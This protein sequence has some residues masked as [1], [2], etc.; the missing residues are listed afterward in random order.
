M[1]G[2]KWIEM[3]VPAGLQ[4]EC[5]EWIEGYYR[6]TLATYHEHFAHVVMYKVADESELHEAWRKIVNSTAVYIQ[7]ELA[8]LLE[9]SNLYVWFWVE[10][11]ISLELKRKIENDTYSSKKFVCQI[12]NKDDK[13]SLL[14]AIEQRIFDLNFSTEKIQKKMLEKV[15]LRNF[16]V[17]KGEKVFSFMRDDSKLARLVVLFAPN[18]IGKTTFFDAVEWNLTS[19]IERFSEIKNRSISGRVLCNT[20]VDL[21]EQSFVQVYMDD[22]AWIKR[23]VNRLDEHNKLDNGNGIAIV[24]QQN[25]LEEYVGT[26]IWKK[27]ILQHHKIDGFMSAHNPNEWYKEWGDL[28]D[29]DYSKRGEF[30]QS[31]NTYR[32][33][34]EEY[35]KIE[36]ERKRAANE[37]NQIKKVRPFVVKLS[38]L[39]NQYQS[40]TGDTGFRNLD[41][42][43]M[44]RA[45]YIAWTDTVEKKMQKTAEE[46][47]VIDNIL[48]YFNT[49]FNE[50][51][52]EYEK[53]EKEVQEKQG[54][55]LKIDKRLKK[56]SEKDYILREI[57]YISE[58]KEKNQKLLSEYFYFVKK[59]ADWYQK[60]ETYFQMKNNDSS[61][62]IIENISQQIRSE[63]AEIDRIN[64][65]IQKKKKELKEQRVLKQLNEHTQEIMGLQEDNQTLKNSIS[66][67]ESRIELITKKIAE[68]EKKRIIFN[69]RFLNDLQDAK[70]KY[71]L[72]RLK[73][74]QD[75][76]EFDCD[77]QVLADMSE[78]FKEY[79]Q[80]LNE[81]QQLYKEIEEAEVIEKD[82]EGIL[83]NIRKIIRNK[84]LKECPVCHTSFTS[85]ENLIMKT[86]RPITQFGKQKKSSLALC[87]KRCGKLLEK[88]EGYIERYNNCLEE[89]LREELD[90]ENKL[91]SEYRALQEDIELWNEALDKQT[92]RMQ[93]IMKE[94]RDNKNYIIYTKGGVQIWR[95]KWE[96][97][98]EA[99]CKELEKQ[100]EMHEKMLEDYKQIKD[101]YEKQYLTFAEL[102]KEIGELRENVKNPERY[103]GRVP[104]DSLTEKYVS[105]SEKKSVYEESLA[106]LKEQKEVYKAYAISE[107]KELTRKRRDLNNVLLDKKNQLYKI[108]A[109][110]RKNIMLEIDPPDDKQETIFWSE[111]AQRLEKEKERQERGIQ[112]LEAMKYNREVEN[113]F[114]HWREKE[115]KLE[116]LN[117]ASLDIK[118]DKNRARKNYEECQSNMTAQMQ[119]FL[120]NLSIGSIYEKLEPHEKMKKLICRFQYSKNGLPGLNFYAKDKND[121]TY[122]PEWYFSTAQLNVVAFSLFLGRALVSKEA[123]LK[124]IMIDDPIGHFDEMNIVGFVD[125]LRSIV[126]QTDRQIIISTH[127]ERVFEL[128]KRKIPVTEYP[129]KYF[130][131]ESTQ[132]FLM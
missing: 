128:I 84:R 129:V 104:Y 76:K 14:K 19:E 68:I 45:E 49:E 108:K 34:K 100:K 5:G 10:E 54:E 21:D 110:I 78:A 37:Y 82:L 91:T 59:G 72:N 103:I 61:K 69:D 2:S 121:E 55:I 36:N 132:D 58:R 28:W 27:L 62:D 33:S 56:I 11:E 29:Q 65:E 31:Y 57:K 42:S 40:I 77:K 63:V 46:C 39:V 26:G 86:I 131:L 89:Y 124:T 50:D 102:S 116:K 98:I 101:Q 48:L 83:R 74:W 41:F 85:T 112:C 7:G 94:D 92:R 130:N 60:M 111:C 99:D 120:N 24:S 118:R 25:S 90:R 107:K 13:N 47:K 52:V 88:I 93:A 16:R 23:E 35:I 125:L 81:L 126:E 95:K 67:Y 105:L 75:D 66:D 51:K 113:Y 20:D 123:L 114:E 71:D 70:K 1:S 73:A 30:E 106:K 6:R 3:A 115:N 87:N 127:E 9:R 109:R 96:K 22:G 18:G 43:K 44:N 79:S 8:S 122:S 12:Q 53:L 38:R 17:Y 97:A 64:L 117:K 4:K 119:E 80:C 32:K 15:I